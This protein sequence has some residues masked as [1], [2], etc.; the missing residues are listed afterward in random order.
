M[1]QIAHEQRQRPVGV[2]QPI[3]A[4]AV[5][6]SG[7]GVE[8]REQ[9]EPAALVNRPLDRGG[10]VDQESQRPQMLLVGKQP[11]DRIFDDHDSGQLVGLVR[12][13]IAR[14]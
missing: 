11:V 4:A 14:Q 13:G 5:A 2:R 8:A 6:Q 7:Q 3:E 9:I 10:E 12:Q 1:V